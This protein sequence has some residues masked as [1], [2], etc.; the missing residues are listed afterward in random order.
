MARI[1]PDPLLGTVT[2][3]QAG[4]TVVAEFRADRLAYWRS[5]LI[6]AVVLGAAA[7]LVLMWLGNPYP[8]AGPFGAVLAIGVRAAYL[9][10]EALSETWR[11]TDR[12]LL[13]P[14]GRAIPRAQIRDARAFLGSVQV[15]TTTGDRCLIKYQSDPAASATRIQARP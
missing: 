14:G 13:G 2:P 1:A 15:T 10:S 5:H 7:G 11:L 9:A 3:L 4:E 8:V 6:M 12:R